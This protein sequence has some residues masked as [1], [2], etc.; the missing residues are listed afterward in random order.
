[1]LN[2]IFTALLFFFIVQTVYADEMN[3]DKAK[4][5][6]PSSVIVR[7]TEHKFVSLVIF[8]GAPE[9]LAS[10][11]AEPR[12]GAQYRRLDSRNTYMVCEYKELLEKLVI[13]AKGATFCGMKQIG[14]EVVPLQGACWDTPSP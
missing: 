10:L 14:S 13:H 5:T 9:H 12:K 3:L 2:K 6:C 11:I 8:D 7:G 4:W 1:M